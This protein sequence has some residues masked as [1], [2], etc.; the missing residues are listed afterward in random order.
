MTF[1]LVKIY[2]EMGLFAKLVAMGLAIMAIASLAVFV[3]RLWAYARARRRSLAFGE[4]AEQLLDQQAYETLAKRSQEF[5]G[6]P[7]AQMVSWGLKAYLT[8]VKKPGKVS[9]VELAKRE[10]DRRAEA[11]TGQVRRG[12]SLLATVGSIAPFVGLLGTVVG[13]IAAFQG[14][15][16][17]GSGGLGAVSAGIAEALIETAFGLLVAIPAVLAFNY[18]NGRADQML[19]ALDQSR[20]EFIDAL[21]SGVG[22]ELVPHGAQP[23]ARTHAAESREVNVG[24][25]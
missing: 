10:L 23:K 17:E 22:H 7:L 25:A 15:A 12:L 6:S 16:K 21:E 3:E 5:K 8:A 13:I 24:A 19:T 20:G 9:P 11:Q 14:I 18:L 1:D 4:I 2:H